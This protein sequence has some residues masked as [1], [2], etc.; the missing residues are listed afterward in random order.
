[1]NVRRV[2][3]SIPRRKARRALVVVTALAFLLQGLVTQTHIHGTTANFGFTAFLAKITAAYETEDFS[4]APSKNSP[5]KD[6][7][8]RCPFCQAAQSAGSFVTP[9]AVV[10]LLPWQNVPV[11]PLWVADN[12]R[13]P[14]AS[15]DWRGRAP[16]SA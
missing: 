4:K 14:A 1:M 2:M 6:D 11:V 5:V 13:I 16:P 3:P 8:A 7:A 15:H 9:V 12:T 10:L